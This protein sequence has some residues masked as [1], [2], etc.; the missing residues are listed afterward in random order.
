M[1]RVSISP[2]ACA[3]HT[4][5]V[6]KKSSVVYAKA[7]AAVAVLAGVMRTHF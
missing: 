3:T 1:N 7:A 6:D 2:P 4:R 5:S